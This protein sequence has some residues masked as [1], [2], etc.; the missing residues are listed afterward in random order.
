MSEFKFG[1]NGKTMSMAE[2]LSLEFN[3]L[4]LDQDGL[5]AYNKAISAFYT[6]AMS[7]DYDLDKVADSVKQVL[8]DS[9]VTDL[10]V[11]V[12]DYSL[13]IKGGNVSVID[14]RSE[15]AEDAIKAY[16]KKNKLNDNAENRKT[17]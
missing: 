16:L 3:D 14:W 15:G 10:E 17:A 4:G 6:A 12:G 1:I 2:W 8:I 11:D 9:G 7:N 5:R 13:I